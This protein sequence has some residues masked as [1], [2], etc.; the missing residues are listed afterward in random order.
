MGAGDRSG[1]LYGGQPEGRPADIGYFIGYRIAQAYYDKSEDK[2]AAVREILQVNEFR[3]FLV[4]SG[5][6]PE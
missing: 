4:E 5:Y 1:W 2:Q 6:E 3:A